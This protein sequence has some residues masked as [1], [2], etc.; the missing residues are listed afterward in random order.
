MIAAVNRGEPDVLWVWMTAPKQEKWIYENR[1]KLDL[2]LAKRPL[3]LP[4][5]LKLAFF[6]R[7]DPIPDAR[8]RN[9]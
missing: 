2:H 7:L 3:L 6:V 8:G 5:L 4:D 9:R 1:D